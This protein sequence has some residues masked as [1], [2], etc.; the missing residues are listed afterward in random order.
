M[1]ALPGLAAL[2]ALVFASL[3]IRATN[4]QLQE[5]RQQ[6]QIAEQGQIT[7]RYNAA[8]THLGSASTDIRLGG[9]Y[10]LQRLMQDSPRD[11]PTII[12]VLCAYIRNQTTETAAKPR[13]PPTHAGQPPTDIQAALTVIDT[14][15]GANDGTT[16]VVNLDQAQ[17]TGAY[18]LSANFAHANLAGANLAGA[19]L[20]GANLNS[21]NLAHANLD[22]SRLFAAD[23]DRANLN[24]ANLAHANLG[25]ANLDSAN[26]D[27]SRL[28]AAN[29]NF[30]DLDHARLFRA[31]LGGANLDNADLFRANLNFADL[32]G[33]SLFRADLFRAN[34]ESASLTDANLFGA[35]LTHADLRH[36]RANR[37]GPPPRKANRR[38]TPQPGRLP[39]SKPHLPNATTSRHDRSVNLRPG[40]AS[41]PARGTT[42]T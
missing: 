5:T 14:R 31:N 36:A 27:S 16:T 8:I 12:A 4:G 25:S 20:A 29:L 42:A 39:C 26:L 3:S 17:L 23:L 32:E 6:L 18:L 1:S 10:A 38:Q 41:P 30:A 15:N 28:F 7:D 19:N 40:T 34:L 24:S 2:I 21:A 33:A 22:S 11:Q 37:R 9:I 13:R 35:N